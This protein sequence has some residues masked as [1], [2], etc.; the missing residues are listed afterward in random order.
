MKLKEISN[1]RKTKIKEVET[2]N[3]FLF[4]ANQ[5]LQKE[6]NSL[7]EKIEEMSKQLKEYE[8]RS[9]TINNKN[10]NKQS[11][12]HTEGKDIIAL[13]GS[14]K[15]LTDGNSKILELDTNK[16]LENQDYQEFEFA[17]ILVC[18]KNIQISKLRKIK[19]MSENRA[20]F[21]DSEKD[22]INYLKVMEE[23]NENR[24]N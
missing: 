5:K 12:V 17:E 22:V 11:S 7:L 13:I 4:E 21:F 23:N 15:I 2:K 10:G 24:S 19:K 14:E 20:K 8:L 6:I 9:N 18:K 1:Q 16:Y 3:I